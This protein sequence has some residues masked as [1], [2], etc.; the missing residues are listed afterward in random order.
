MNECIDDVIPVKIL[1]FCLFGEVFF[2]LLQN[3]SWI[4]VY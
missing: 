2:A 3:S 1:V 4:H